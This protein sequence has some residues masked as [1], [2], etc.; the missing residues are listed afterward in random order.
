M[1][2]EWRI[3]KDLEDC[4]GLILIYYTGIRLEGLRKTTKTSVRIARLLAE[5][6]TQELPNM[7]QEC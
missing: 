2:C 1:M 5:I 7:E 4:R 3:G 6:W